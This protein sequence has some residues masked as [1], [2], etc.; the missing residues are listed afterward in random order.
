MQ[1][2]LLHMRPQLYGTIYLKS[3]VRDCDSVGIFRRKLKTNLFVLAYAVLAN[4]SHL[5]MAF[6]PH[7]VFNY[8][9]ITITKSQNLSF[10]HLFDLI[11]IEHFSSS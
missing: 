10:C 9:Y 4:V 2:V 3:I 1:V 5:R 8:N 7:M 6:M 11:D